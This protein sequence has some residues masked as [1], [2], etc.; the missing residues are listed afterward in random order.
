[1]TTNKK[2]C[3][4]VGTR[5]DIIKM[6]PLIKKMNPYVIHSGQHRELADEAF[7]IFDIK[8][9]TDL[10][11]MEANQTIISFMVKG[12]SAISRVVEEIKPKRIWVLGDTMTALITSWVAFALEIPLVHVEAGLRTHDKRNPYPEEIFRVMIDQIADIMFTPTKTNTKNLNKERV[13][14]DIHQVGNLIVDALE[15]IKPTLSEKRPIEEP[16]VLMT[17]HRRES[18]QKDMGNVFGAVKELSKKMKVI[19]PIH[20]NPNVRKVAKEI[21]IT[22]IDPLNY[23]DFLWYLK[24]CEFVMTDS[25]GIQEEVPSFDKPILILRKVTERQEILKSKLAFLSS[26][27]SKD[28]YEKVRILSKMKDVKYNS[29][30]FGDGKTADRI[31]KIIEEKYE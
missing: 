27:E 19:Y 23:T 29:N 26:L 13:T 22:T 2:E 21:G 28:V 24:H 7:K 9:D 25:G 1:M 6:A 11:L 10:D 20:P 12:A 5:P 8:P 15:M 4:V 14:G 3:F 30:P 17:M 31:I 16:Y 18:F